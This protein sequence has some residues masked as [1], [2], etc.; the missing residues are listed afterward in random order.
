MILEQPRRAACLASLAT[1]A[2]AIAIALFAMRAAA[3]VK[4]SAGALHGGH[5]PLFWS[6]Q[7]GPGGG[8]G[9]GGDHTAAPPRKAELR[10]TDPR[11]VPAGEQQAIDVSTDARTDTEPIPRLDIPVATLALG[12]E[13]FPG[14]IDAPSASPIGSRGPGHGDGAGDG[15]GKGDGPGRGAGFGDGMDGGIGGDAYRPG[16]GVT[17]PIEIRKGV[18]QYTTEAMHARAQG[19][20][21]VE[22]LVQTT[23]VCTNIRV[24]RSL[25]P[26]FGLDQE[27]IKAAAQWRFRP[28]MRR[29][30]P[31]PVLVNMEIVFALR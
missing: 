20:I 8:G 27:A 14:A 7:P 29:G 16:S 24:K 4:N 6:R 30:E 17:M 5:V 22:C 18:P 1:H 13:A 9:G 12:N 2:G 25:N 15:R 21:I 23:G 11:T 31:V 26:S 28:G 3:P 10:G 19:T